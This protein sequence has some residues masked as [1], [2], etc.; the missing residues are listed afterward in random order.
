MQKLNMDTHRRVTKGIL[1]LEVE[2]C[3][4]TSRCYSDA[5]PECSAEACIH[6]TRYHK[7]Q[8][9][10]LVGEPS[11]GEVGIHNERSAEQGLESNGQLVAVA[12]E[13]ICQDLACTIRSV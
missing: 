2:A 8:A 13:P 10:G 7:Q 4:L 9:S 5:R 12:Q 1:C 6:R 11:K 3:R